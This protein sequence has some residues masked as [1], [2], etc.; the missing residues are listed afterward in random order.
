[1]TGGWSIIRSGGWVVEDV[2]L[3]IRTWV[4]EKTR[5][6]SLDGYPKYLRPKE[7]LSVP[8]TYQDSTF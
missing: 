6:L 5:R 3:R 2:C 7:N 8:I 1:M 4:P